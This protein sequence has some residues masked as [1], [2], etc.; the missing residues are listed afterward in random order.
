MPVQLFTDHD[1]PGDNPFQ[2]SSPPQ[3]GNVLVHEQTQPVYQQL[4]M[5]DPHNEVTQA[6]E[7]TI[8]VTSSRVVS[9]SR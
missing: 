9:K 5:E 4:A 1:L 8:N 3:A 2:L 7:G 6:L